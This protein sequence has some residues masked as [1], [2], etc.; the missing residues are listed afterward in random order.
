MES[1]EG[2]Y[3]CVAANLAGSSNGVVDLNVISE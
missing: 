1:D 3:L 2:Q